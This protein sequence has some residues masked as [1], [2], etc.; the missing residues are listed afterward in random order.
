[1][2]LWMV[3][4]GKHGEYE[5]QTLSTNKIYLTWDDLKTDLSKIADRD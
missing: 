5:Q 3:R 2:A 4:V 1:M